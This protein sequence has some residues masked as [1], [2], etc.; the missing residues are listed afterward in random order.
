MRSIRDP[1]VR[2]SAPALADLASASSQSTHPLS[3]ICQVL[4]SMVRWRQRMPFGVTNSRDPVL[5][6]LSV[7]G[8][9]RDAG[10]SEACQEFAMRTAPRQN[11]N[12]IPQAKIARR[13]SPASRPVAEGFGVRKVP[14]ARMLHHSWRRR[15]QRRLV[16]YLA[17]MTGNDCAFVSE[18]GKG[19]VLRKPFGELGRRLRSAAAPVHV[20]CRA[21]GSARVGMLEHDPEKWTPVFRKGLSPRKRGSCSTNNRAG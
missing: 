10:L 15:D 17:T 7:D 6:S 12:V 14:A 19:S 4:L 2:R 16:F 13:S 8:W 20:S 9:D 21:L 18:D 3:R 11:P 1:G 5:S